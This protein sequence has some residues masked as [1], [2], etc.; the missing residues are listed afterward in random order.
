MKEFGFF[1]ELSHGSPDGPSLIIGGKVLTEKQKIVE[2]LIGCPVLAISGSVV[3]DIISS[4]RL[5]P[6]P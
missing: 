6:V 5:R 3:Y 1:R 2:Y 4:G